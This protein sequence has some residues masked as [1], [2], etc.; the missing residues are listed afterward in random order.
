MKLAPRILEGRFVRLEPYVQALK[1]E[2]REALDCDPE[3]WGLMGGAGYGDH[4]ERWWSVRVGLMAKGTEIPYAVRRL[5]DGRLVGGSSLMA[6]RPEHRGLEIG[7]TFLRPE[8]RAGAVNP[9]MKLLMLAESFAAGVVRVEI[10]TDLRNRRSRA[11]IAKLGA[12]HEGVLRRHKITWTGHIRDTVMFSI[13]DLEW[14]AVRARLQAR[15]AA[16]A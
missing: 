4:F 8:A 13:T 2:L 12:I 15:V 16:F 9:E 1:G 3:A 14:P 6:L 10:L 7:G 11:A 5:S